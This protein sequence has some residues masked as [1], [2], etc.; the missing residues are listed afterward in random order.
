M[1]PESAQNTVLLQTHQKP[2]DS[3]FVAPILKQCRFR[4]ISQ[5]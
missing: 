1:E 2:E 3:G 4:K 5:R